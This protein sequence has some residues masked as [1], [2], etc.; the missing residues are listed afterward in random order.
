LSETSE[1]IEQAC[2][3]TSAEGIARCASRGLIE[4]YQR[5]HAGEPHLVVLQGETGMGK[6]RLASAFVGWTQAQVAQV[7][8]GKT[9]PTSTWATKTAGSG[10]FFLFMLC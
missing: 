6:T 2:E 7:L 3:V 9:L 8:V 10:N 5:V 4:S 1:S